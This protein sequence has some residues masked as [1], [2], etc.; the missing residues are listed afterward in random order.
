MLLRITR[1]CDIDKER[2]MDVYSEGNLK[3]ASYFYPEETDIEA[4]VDKVKDGFMEFLQKDF[5]AHDDATYWV[6][7][8][9]GA[10]VSALRTCMVKP[11]TYYLEALE[12]PPAQRNRGF[13]SKLM[14][15]VLETMKQE[16]SFQLY[17]CVSKKNT[18]SL[19]TH[20]KC[21][22]TIATED[23]YDYLNNAVEVRDYGMV[24]YYNKC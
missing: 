7:E 14:L 4:A 20:L 11:G 15:E 22:F 5:F 17:D 19:K 24:Y 23:G 9:N 18:P 13:A 16:G 6:L 10:W 2:L 1:Y 3:N 8:E 12:T 21:G